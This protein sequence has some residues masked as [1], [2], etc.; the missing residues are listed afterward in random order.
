M[1][2][3][4]QYF[5]NAATSSNRLYAVVFARNK[6]PKMIWLITR[7][8]KSIVLGLPEIKEKQMAVFNNIITLDFIPTI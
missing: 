4:K 6:Q 8:P 3:S 5:Y 2:K 1:S 7:T